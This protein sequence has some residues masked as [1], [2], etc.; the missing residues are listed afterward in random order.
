MLTS[1]EHLDSGLAWLFVFEFWVRQS[2]QLCLKR[3]YTDE[4]EK[5]SPW[6]CFPCRS[7][8]YELVGRVLV[9]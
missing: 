8:G 9:G 2:H 5:V 7:F 4:I 6:R 3:D 1:C